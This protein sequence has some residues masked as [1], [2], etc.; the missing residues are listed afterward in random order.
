MFWKLEYVEAV[1]ANMEITITQYI[2]P[3]WN[4]DTFSVSLR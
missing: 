3:V 1:A 4:L 2:T